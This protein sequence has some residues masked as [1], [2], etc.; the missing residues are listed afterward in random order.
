MPEVP[1][2]YL[3]LEG[4]KVLNMEVVL[5][6][7]AVRGIKNPSRKSMAIFARVA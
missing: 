5:K 1:C 3:V 4:G 2:P 6:E 7:C